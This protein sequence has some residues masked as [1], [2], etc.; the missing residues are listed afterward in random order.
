[1]NKQDEKYLD[2]LGSFYSDLKDLPIDNLLDDPEE[3][4]FISVDVTN[5][6]CRTGNLA[7]ERVAAIIG[8][9]TGLFK[10]AWKKDLKKMRARAK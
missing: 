10:L 9:I 3:A 6:F 4:A 1:M 2:F 7:S 8:P 5:A